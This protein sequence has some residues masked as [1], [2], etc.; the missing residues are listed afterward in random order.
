MCARNEKTN[1][2][3]TTSDIFTFLCGLLSLSTRQVILDPVHFGIDFRM[4]LRPT[5]ATGDRG[6][7]KAETNDN[8]G[9]FPRPTAS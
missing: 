6:P 7:Y 5:C 8:L 3:V 2:Y 1:V 4:H 9:L